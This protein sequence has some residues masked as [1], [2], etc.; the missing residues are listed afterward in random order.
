MQEENLKV[1]KDYVESFNQGYELSKELGLKSDILEGL[2]SGN[3]R[4]Q[5][6]QDGMKQYEKDQTLEKSKAPDKDVIPPIDLDSL[7]NQNLYLGN[8]DVEP[9]KSPDKDL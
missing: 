7:D 9:N 3:N 1:D 2:S 8:Q 6:M 4:M 5:A